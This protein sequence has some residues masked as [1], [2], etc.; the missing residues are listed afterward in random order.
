MRKPYSIVVASQKGG[1][2]KTSVAVN[3]AVSL[4]YAGFRTLL[5]D[6][7]SINPS[8]GIHLGIEDSRKGCCSVMR[9]RS[10]LDESLVI[11]PRSGLYVL[12][13]EAMQSEEGLQTHQVERATEEML[14]GD[15]D[16]VIFDTSPGSPIISCIHHIDYGIVVMSPDMP[17][18]ASSIRLGVLFDRRNVSHGLV[19]NRIRNRKYEL[20]VYDIEH[21]YGGKTI[22][23]LGDDDV[24]PM[25]ISMHVPACLLKRGA[26]FSSG[27]L[28]LAA[29]CAQRAGKRGEKI[30][31]LRKVSWIDRILRRERRLPIG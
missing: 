21:E 31:E 13:G 20:G 30:T 2:G 9:G 12:L 8:V 14:G 16:F 23:E 27:I 11:H 6:T 24:V 19:I 3:L 25:S 17:S 15:Y 18:F 22:G 26:R 5:V 7:D 29:F 28:S 4:S 1:V 10:K